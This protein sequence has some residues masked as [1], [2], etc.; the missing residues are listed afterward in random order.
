[1]VPEINAGTIIIDV[2]EPIEEDI[3]IVETP[4]EEV[5]EETPTEEILEKNE[6]KFN[7][8]GTH[9]PYYYMYGSNNVQTDINER[10][11]RTKKLSRNVS[12]SQRRKFR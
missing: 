12:N 8:E 5:K 10:S 11:N 7:N 4:I 3:N 2:N 1:M 9:I 6:I